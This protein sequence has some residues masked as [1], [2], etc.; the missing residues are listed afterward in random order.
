MKKTQSLLSRSLQDNG[1]I[2]TYLELSKS[3]QV[4]VLFCVSVEITKIGSLAFFGK[5]EVFENQS[6][7]WGGWGA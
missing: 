1:D 5:N 7:E 4:F 2:H 6:G 3:E